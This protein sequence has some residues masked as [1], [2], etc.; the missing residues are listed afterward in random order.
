MPWWQVVAAATPKMITSPI[1]RSAPVRSGHDIP[2]PNLEEVWELFI[3]L[4]LDDSA[5]RDMF[6]QFAKSSDWQIWHENDCI[7]YELRHDT[8]R[9]GE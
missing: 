6:Q 3:A 4:D 7:P 9:L 8:G 1:V 5:L 2:D